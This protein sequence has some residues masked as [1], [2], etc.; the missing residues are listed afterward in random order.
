MKKI[1]CYLLIIAAVA[2]LTIPFRSHADSP[3]T[4]TS[5][6]TAYLD[7]EEVVKASKMS[8][9]N[10]E[11]ARYLSDPDNPIDIKA[12]IINAI[13]WDIKDEDGG[14]ATFENSSAEDFYNING[15]IN[16]DR[17]SR[18]VFGKPINDLV[19]D[20]LTAHD[21]FCIGYFMAMDNYSDPEPAAAL[22]E[23]ASEA[24]PD[25]FT[26][27]IITAIV[28]A[29]IAF[30]NIEEWDK[31]WELVDGVLSNKNM[32]QDMRAEAVEI[33]V[34]YTISYKGFNDTK[35][36]ITNKPITLTYFTAL[37]KEAEGFE[38]SFSASEI[39]T[40][41]AN[42]TNITI[43]FIHTTEETQLQK[44]TLMAAAGDTPDL[45]EFPWLS[46]TRVTESMAEL[47]VIIPLD[48]LIN[49]IAPN[50]H[51]I[52]RSNP[53]AKRQITSGDDHIYRN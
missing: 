9:V 16:A 24:I 48:E 40:E 11:L 50:L 49:E 31:V 19:L 1:L 15:K 37:P 44:L 14:D 21:L 10:E 29:Q 43:S 42:R 22:L 5:F 33:I 32:V 18:F 45:I 23:K 20:N 2:T 36:L 38:E 35:S 41:L 12:A 6:Y 26:I 7:I 13:S 3:V 25:S 17:Y 27:A 53:E 8:W 39:Y 30:E 51:G 47:G 52:L 28:K 46:H 34:D 4:S